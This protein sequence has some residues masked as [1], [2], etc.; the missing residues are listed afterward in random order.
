MR[1]T[2]EDHTGYQQKLS[3]LI[4]MDITI[5]YFPDTRPN[6]AYSDIDI[7]VIPYCRIQVSDIPNPTVEPP[8]TVYPLINVN[9]VTANKQINSKEPITVQGTT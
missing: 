4:G 3:P 7:H 8:N 1:K 5:N 2:Q 6:S 9:A